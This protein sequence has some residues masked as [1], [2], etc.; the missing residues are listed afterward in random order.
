[1]LATLWFKVIIDVGKSNE[2]QSWGS[3]SGNRGKMDLRD[4][5]EIETLNS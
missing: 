1:M 5:R 2:N 3:G 4:G